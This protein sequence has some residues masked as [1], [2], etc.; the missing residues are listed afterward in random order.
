VVDGERL[1]ARVIVGADGVNGLTAR[2]F[3][4]AR[5][6][7]HGVAL[8]GNAPLDTRYR[9]RLVLELGVVPGGYAWV[10]PKGDHAN[11]GIGGWESEGPRLRE[12]LARLCEVHGARADDLVDVRG[13]R[14]PLRAPDSR[15]ARGRALVVGDA[16]GLIDP[17]SGDG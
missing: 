6:H 7:G 5:D 4:L 17:V 14:L 13:Y 11:F 10:F 8:E 2:T 1:G 3:G 16:A 9:G 12:A 15:L